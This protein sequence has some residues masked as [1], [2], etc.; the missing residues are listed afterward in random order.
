MTERPG[1][2][3]RLALLAIACYQGAWSSRRPSACRFTPSCSAY[4]ATAI[5][6]FGVIRGIWLGIRRIARCQPFRPGG[7]D[8]VPAPADARRAPEGNLH[9]A[10]G[11]GTDS[12]R[13]SSEKMTLLEQAG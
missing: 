8:P 11:E 5:T 13:N 12:G 7:Y 9:A 1:P 6:D 10:P 4:A 3:A 2:A